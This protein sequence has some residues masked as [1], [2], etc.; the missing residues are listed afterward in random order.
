MT[1]TAD[2]LA[3]VIPVL[4]AHTKR[5]LDMII[6]ASARQPIYLLGLCH[7]PKE[8]GQQQ[9]YV[10]L[11]SKK[12]VYD[13]LDLLESWCNYKFDQLKSKD[14]YGLQD[15]EDAIESDLRW[16]ALKK[17]GV[18][19]DLIEVSNYFLCNRDA[20]FLPDE[21]R[22]CPLAL[23]FT[24]ELI[25]AAAEFESREDADA[26]ILL[27]Q[28]AAESIYDDLTVAERKAPLQNHYKCESCDHSRTTRYSCVLLDSG[29]YSISSIAPPTVTVIGKDTK[30]SP[31]VPHVTIDVR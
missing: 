17:Y 2:Q 24:R 30:A 22:L 20:K 18:N 12:R 7:P 29:H 10:A 11:E 9:R 31:R 14:D 19:S 26:D 16:C 3:E 25:Y 1:H 13:L 5:L 27:Y 4:V 21:S 23:K 6:D 28:R 8:D 15:E